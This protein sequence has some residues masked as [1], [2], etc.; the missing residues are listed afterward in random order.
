MSARETRLSDFDSS[1]ALIVTGPTASGKSALALWLAQRFN[2]VIINADSMQVYSELRILTARPTEDDE[3]AAPHMLYGVRPAAEAGSVAWWREAALFEMKAARQSGK[4]PILCGGTGLYLASLTAGLVDI[5]A[6][7]PVARHEARA[8]L[9]AEGPRALHHRLS[10][11]DPVTADRLNPADGQRLAR[12]YEVWRSTG[13]GLADWQSQPRSPAT[14]D[15]AAIRLEPPREA[16]RLAIAARF[17]AMLDQGV[18]AEVEKLLDL[19]LDPALPAMRAHGVPELGACL[20]GRISLGEARVRIG[21]ATS[22]YTKRQTTWLRH[23]ILADTRRTHTIDARFTCDTQFS[24]RFG[25]D[26]EN[27]M[28]RT[29]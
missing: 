6:P 14:W 18:L 11:V 29:T 19:R 24:E 8:L 13:R 5:P 15:F 4:L 26:L 28:K 27:F 2:G 20:Q 10:A 1:P 23:H 12:A 16:L 3:R 7:S 22:R 21:G 9:A 17:D 25:A